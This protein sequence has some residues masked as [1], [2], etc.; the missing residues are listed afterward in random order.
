MN[1]KASAGNFFEDFSLGETIQH[2]TP[3]TITAGDVSLYIALTGSRFLLHSSKEAAKSFGFDDLLVDNLLVFHIAFGKT[4]AD[5]SVNAIANLGYAEV[6]F[7]AAA[8]IGDTLSV[9]SE[10]IGL[11]ENSNKKSGIVYVHS[12]ATNQK[13]NVVLSWKR[14]VMVHKKSAQNIIAEL[15]IPELKACLPVNDLQIA[16]A[17]NSE[18][19]SGKIS[20]S[21]YLWDD[22]QIG[23]RIDHIDGMTIDNSDH[24][25]AT[26]LYQN[27]ARVHFDALYM[28]DTPHQQRLMYGG[29]VIS[30]CRALS[31][32]GLA[33]GLLVAAINAGTH[34]AP[35]FAGDTLYACSQVVDRWEIADKKGIAALRLKTWGIKN[36]PS[37]SVITPVENQGGKQKFHPNVVLELDYTVLMPR[38]I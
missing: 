28:Q 4:V 27:N 19:F 16:S 25:L 14:W 13:N 23:E 11:R 1:N 26:K 32:N 18:T 30:I 20:G 17:L 12:I 2:A 37:E 34:C 5:I 10:V 6:K 29:H 3:R 31:F 38:R 7:G 21:N 35:T 36:L 22:Y 24:T 8:Y 9:Q 15:Q 33:N